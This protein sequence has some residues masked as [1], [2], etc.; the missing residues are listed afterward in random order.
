MTEL[1]LL[2][3]CW[4]IGLVA[5]LEGR[6]QTNLP[7][8]ELDVLPTNGS[9]MISE[10]TNAVFVTVN[11]ADAF[12][13]I[14]IAGEFGAQTNIA[15]LDDGQPPDAEATNAVFSGYLI[16]PYV[17]TPTVQILRLVSSGEAPPTERPPDPPIEPMVQ[18]N[19]FEYTIL[20]RPMNDK[21]TNA[22]RI[23]TGG[24]VVVSSNSFA[25]IEP[26][27]PRHAQ[28]AGVAS[29]VWWNWSPNVTT[30][31]LVDLG[32]SDF[33]AVLAVYTGTTISN[34]VEVKSG[35]ND[36][37]NNLRAHV[38]FNARAGSTYRIAVSGYESEAMGQ[39][40]LRVA[41]GALPD[42][43][44]PVVTIA[45]PASQSVFAAP[46]V[47][48]QGSAKERTAN[49]SGVE[50]VVLQV[51][52]DTNQ[53][54][55]GGTE[56]WNAV[57][58]L[59]VGTN[60][61]RAVGYDYN[62][63]AGPP[64]A[65]VVR[66]VNPI[67]D[68]F[69]NAILLGED[70]GVESAGST[71]ATIEP[72][73]PL[74]AMNEGG[75][76]VWY[77][78]RAPYSGELMLSTEGSD[79]DTLLGLYIGTALTNLIEV[80]SND[81]AFPGSGHSQLRQK[82]V[83]NQLY[84]IAADGYGGS[85]GNVILTYVFSITETLYSLD[86]TS[87]L[88]GTVSPPSGLY[89]E[90]SEVFVNAIPATD[91]LFAHWEDSGGQVVS[92]QNPLRLVMDRNHS[93]IARFVLKSYSDT[94]GSGD[95]SRLPWTGSGAKGWSVAMV[96]GQYVAQSG[97]IG[98][99]QT[100]SLILI[101]YLYDGTGA[102]D[103]SVSS[104]EGWD[105]LEFYVDG[106]RLGRWSGDVLWQTFMFPIT[107]G[108][109]VLEWRYA[110]D[111]NYSEGLDRAFIDN[112]YLPLQQPE[113][114]NVRPSIDVVRLANGAVQLTVVCLPN[115]SYVIEASPNLKTWTAVSTNRPVSAAFQW[116]DPDTLS[117]AAR[118]YR[119]VAR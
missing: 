55:A 89:P 64:A 12:T 83:G 70:G 96:E 74:H 116:L 24:G 75:H 2:H 18:T 91:Y 23:A 52:N 32:G 63:N 36:V 60:L 6:A 48:F 107:E 35:T 38:N 105:A 57:V 118:F 5:A 4:A 15:F 54:V 109:R 113:P 56:A 27:E 85:A 66:Y 69:A 33:D 82:V 68:M 51:N 65:V 17:V 114:P 112:V 40:R 79:F 62:G 46:N 16:T 34:L 76:S 30:N 42:A 78:W 97:S 1:H 102:F 87:P 49:A 115:V 19:E 110:K 37:V 94:F 72:G 84:Y 11:N 71:D 108:R 67:N 95:L 41:A 31:V 106:R 86:L 3:A 93:L 13:N 45:S 103:L 58:T 28:V 14:V 88:G 100:S 25:S 44:G 73:E 29:S 26:G 9:I 80:A 39:V 90:G 43:D 50:R 47:A 104:E 53:I 7:A 22:F 111:A 117:R 101:S 99:G 92:T 119:A 61:V 77:A 10:S 20:P 8:F 21:F 81:E 59:P 98:N